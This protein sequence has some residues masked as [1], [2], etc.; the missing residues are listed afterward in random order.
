MEYD[1]PEYGAAPG[2][3]RPTAAST[4]PHPASA[5]LAA[6]ARI[7]EMVGAVVTAG[8]D[9]VALSAAALA[10]LPAAD[11]REAVTAAVAALPGL[12][13]LRLADRYGL[14]RLTAVWLHTRPSPATTAAYLAD[15]T[16]YLRWCAGQRLDPLRAYR[17]DLDLWA[18]T[19]A[20]RYAPATVARKLAVVSSW[21]GYLLAHEVATRNPLAGL[22]RP[23]LDRDTS[24]TVSLSRAEA[25]AFLAAAG[26][27]ARPRALR[28]AALLGLMLTEGLRVAEVCGADI[29]DLGHH[30]GYRTLTVRR[31]GGKTRAYPLAPPI[32]AAVDDYLDDRAACGG[33]PRERLAG[34]LF[35]TEPS[36]PHPGGKRLD[37]WGIT[38]LIRRIARQARI[39]AAAQLSPHSLR[40]SFA[41]LALDAG[42]A[43]RDVQDAMGHA[44]PRTT[45]RYDRSRYQLDRHPAQRI[46]AYL[47]DA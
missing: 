41:T 30:R 25:A 26:A 11:R 35:V 47:T 38:K 22:D 23:A 44:D 18:T 19:L 2:T 15:L 39:P 3:P 28:T 29:A 9:A 43:L 27:D 13:P 46:L 6:S 33:T 21:Y 5:D 8:L 17:A 4:A 16:G 40:H 37:R 12:G 31:K 10:R 45:R 42:T 36:G 14:H 24:A 7:G 20:E 1:D 34:P 32:A